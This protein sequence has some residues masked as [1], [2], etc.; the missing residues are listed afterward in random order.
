MDV[1]PVKNKLVDENYENSIV[2]NKVG[3]GDAGD[4]KDTL[5]PNFGHMWQSTLWGG[6]VPM[7]TPER[8]FQPYK[9]GRSNLSQLSS[10]SRASN[11]NR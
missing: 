10:N 9:T 6:S 1:T 11:N 3:G 2:V 5:D 7:K 8:A 4:K